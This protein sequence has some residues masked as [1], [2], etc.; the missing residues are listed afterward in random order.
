MSLLQ[1]TGAEGGREGGKQRQVM[2]GCWCLEGIK[3]LCGE[4]WPRVVALVVL[5]CTSARI[6]ERAV[7]LPTLVALMV[8]DPFWFTVPPI[9]RDE[10]PRNTGIT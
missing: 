8:N 2:S 1:A 9:T 7:C 3:P 5:A 6:W 10:G 4:W